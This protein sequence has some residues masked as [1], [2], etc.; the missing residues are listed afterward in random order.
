MTLPQTFPLTGMSCGSCASKVTARLLEHPDIAEAE[1]TLQPPQARLQ[2]RSPL[3]HEAVNDWLEP[4]GKYRVPV[5]APAAV[6][7]DQP[8]KNAQTY[9]PLL[10]LLAYLLLVIAAVSFM[11]GGFDLPMAMRLFMGGFFVAFSFFKMLDLRGF[12]DAYRSYD[13]VAKA[14]PAYGFIYPFIELG[15]GLGYLADWQPFW[16]NLTT[17]VV[18]GVSLIGVLKAVLSK[19]AIRCACL[20]T[21]FNLPMSTVTIVEDGLMLAMAVVALVVPH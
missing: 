9:R 10:I 4:L 15:L 11:Q 8:E 21:V 1:V 6:T 18:M 13:L 19:Q 3:S 16:I 5:A 17:V 20:G 7:P 14:L 2:T 12:S